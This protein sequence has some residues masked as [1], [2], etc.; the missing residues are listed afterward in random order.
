MTNTLIIYAHPTRKGHNGVVLKEVEAHLN[1]SKS[2]YKLID[3]YKEHFNPVLT[4]N[5]FN[6]PTNQAKSYQNEIKKADHII[7]IYPVWWG[8]FPAMLKGFFDQVF[9]RGFAFTYKPLPFPVFGMRARP[10]GLLSDKRATVF[11]TMGARKWQNDL[12]LHRISKRAVRKPLLGFCG[13]KSKVCA[14]YSCTKL[15][16]EHKRKAKSLVAKVLK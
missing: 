6:K 16:A 12:F 3:L 4:E 5:N 7:F 9:T 11:I 8:T 2:S 10:I 15:T 14:L 13:I 1:T